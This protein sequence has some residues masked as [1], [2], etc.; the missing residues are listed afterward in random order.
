MD[1]DDSD[2]DVTDTEEEDSMAGFSSD[3]TSKERDAPGVKS[4]SQN[5][6]VSYWNIS[7]WS[8]PCKMAFDHQ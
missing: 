6:M 3:S 2:S 5:N 1:E 4:I 7:S 8:C